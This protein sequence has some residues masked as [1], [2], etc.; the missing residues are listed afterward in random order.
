M[1]S[2]CFIMGSKLVFILKELLWVLTDSQLKAALHFLDSLSGLIK[3]ANEVVRKKKA[4]R[5]LE[6]NMCDKHNN[7]FFYYCF[8]IST[9]LS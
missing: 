3:K 8:V 1:I 7:I 9:S 2:D 5:K 6:V 4:A